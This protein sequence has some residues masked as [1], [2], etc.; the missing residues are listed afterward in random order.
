MFALCTEEGAAVALEGPGEARAGGVEEGAARRAQ[1]LQG[2]VVQHQGQLPSM[3]QLPGTPRYS[4]HQTCVP[5]GNGGLVPLVLPRGV[6][7][8]VLREVGHERPPRLAVVEVVAQHLLCKL[9]KRMRP[10]VPLLT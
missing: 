7:V 6:E 8:V 1:C 2:L 5:Y 4:A 10:S 9:R 3:W